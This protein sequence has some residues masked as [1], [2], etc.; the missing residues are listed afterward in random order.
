MFDIAWA[1]RAAESLSR[2]LSEHPAPVVS[3]VLIWVVGRIPLVRFVAEAVILHQLS[4]T[5][6][7]DEARYEK[8]L[9]GAVDSYLDRIRHRSRRGPFPEFSRANPSIPPNTR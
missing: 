7:L 6:F 4:G 3:I 1:V 8:L 5:R 2:I 9:D